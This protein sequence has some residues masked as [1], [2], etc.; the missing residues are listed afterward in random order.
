MSASLVEPDKLW[1]NKTSLMNHWIFKKRYELCQNSLKIRSLIWYRGIYGSSP[2][3]PL[4]AQ[5]CWTS[6]GVNSIS[7]PGLLA[8]K[9]ARNY[10]KLIFPHEDFIICILSLAIFQM[11]FIIRILA[12]SFYHPAPSGPRFPGT[13]KLLRGKFHFSTFLVEG[14]WLH[15]G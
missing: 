11:R 12:S 5:K 7:W 8:T 6:P 4:P 10:R 13:L 1:W 14:F 9:T 3:R 2:P 15:T